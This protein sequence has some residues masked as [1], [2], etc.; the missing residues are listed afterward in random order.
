[1]TTKASRATVRQR[2]EKTEY[3][4]TVRLHCA[5]LDY[6]PEIK[7]QG[8]KNSQIEEQQCCNEVFRIKID[9]RISQGLS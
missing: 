2:N 9:E 7:G 5:G 1:M 8:C 4:P 3:C 6:F